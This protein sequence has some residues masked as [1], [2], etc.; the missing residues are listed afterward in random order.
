[1]LDLLIYST[2]TKYKARGE[3]PR[4]SSL[5]Y[6]PDTE[7]SYSFMLLLETRKIN[8][9]LSIFVQLLNFL[10]RCL[11]APILVNQVNVVV[12]PEKAKLF[13]GNSKIPVLLVSDTPP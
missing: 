9:S 7:V 5:E 11:N 1:M 4:L 6:L 8:S 12:D 2:V 10:N 13:N 3:R